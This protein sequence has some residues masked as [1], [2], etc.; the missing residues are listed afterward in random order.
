MAARR[1]KGGRRIKKKT[2]PVT[3]T[4][5]STTDVSPKTFVFTKGKVPTK[6]K[7]LV[8][9]LKKVMSPNTATALRAQKKNKLR[10][11][12]DVAGMLQVSFF[13][14]VSATDKNSYLRLVRSPRGPTLTFKIN[15]FS[16]ASDLAAT[17]RK[18][19][20]TSHSLW[21]C[22]PMLVLSNF[23]RQVQ[24]EALSATMLQNL[25]PTLN[26]A[27]ARLATFR[28][29]V[30]V[31]Q[32]P[33]SEG[34]GAQLRQYLIKAAPTGVSKGVKKLMRANKLP[35]L[36]KYSDVADYLT[37]AGYSS[38]SGG[39]TD[40]EDKAELPQDFVGRNARKSQ[41]VSI[42]LHEIGPRLELSLL[43]VEEGLCD[44]ATLYHSLVSKSEEEA[45]ETAARV[46]ARAALKVERK[47]AQA[48]NVAR[49]RAA[50]E[51]R[52]ARRKRRRGSGGS[53]GGDDDDDDDGNDEY[54]GESTTGGG[55]G[56]HADADADDAEWYRREVG[57]EPSPELGLS[58]KR[59]DSIES[60]LPLQSENERAPAIYA[61]A[62]AAAA[63]A[64][65]K[66]KK[67]KH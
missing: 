26:V 20:A 48:E 1:K 41:Q 39:E 35:S 32:L 27:T 23:D 12:V 43:K 51:E 17:Q 60:T 45:A 54:A 5:E 31:H 15:S 16:L 65:A 7:M 10:D 4:A 18:P 63:A 42:K 44:G 6:L 33:E 57:E 21:Q 36:G 37:R 50:D 2:Q 38:D 24:H 29:V 22:E 46:E 34:G 30:L 11:F 13:L 58:R 62:A 61:K 9:E 67:G 59:S 14:I 56:G 49:K 55:L 40:E 19:Q 53:T 3:E 25:F 28:R 47:Q 66:K 52:R 64:K 8:D